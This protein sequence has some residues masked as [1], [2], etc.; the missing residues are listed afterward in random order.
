MQIISWNIRGMGSFVKK[1]ILSKLVK[2]RKP[3][4]VL[5]QETKLE[6]VD[7]AIAQRIWGGLNLDFVFSGSVG[8]SGGFIDFV[9]Y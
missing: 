8:A 2:R 6:L 9:E 1:R 4:M 5:L 3:D 7:R